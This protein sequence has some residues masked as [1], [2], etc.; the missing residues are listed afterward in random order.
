MIDRRVTSFVKLILCKII[1]II[2]QGQAHFSQFN[3]THVFFSVSYFNGKY[4]VS[5]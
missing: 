4:V 3:G 5:Y 1:L 2:S